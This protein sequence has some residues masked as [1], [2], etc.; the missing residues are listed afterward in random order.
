MKLLSGLGYNLPDTHKTRETSTFACGYTDTLIILVTYLEIHYTEIFDQL[1]L[2][3]SVA[4]I[5]PDWSGAI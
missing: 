3:M 5:L 2:F 1:P 4:W